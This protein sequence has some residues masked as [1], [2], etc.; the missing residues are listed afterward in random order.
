[1]K[2]CREAERPGKQSGASPVAPG[3]LYVVA[4]PIGNLED[5]TLRAL[6]VLK[7]VDLIAAEDT[8][9]SR[10]LLSHFG[11]STS[12]TSYFEHNQRVKG[13]FLI[14]K[15]EGGESV[16][17]ITDAGTPCISDPGYLLVAEAV[18]AGITVVPI[19]GACAAV[20]ALSAS[21]L[22]TDSFLFLGFLPPRGAKR[23]AKLLDVSSNQHVF[24]LYESPQRLTETIEDIYRVLGDR[25]VVVAREITKIHEEFVRGVA[26]DVLEV[27]RNREARGEVV[28]FVSPED[29]ASMVAIPD[30]DELLRHHIQVENVSVKEAVARVAAQTGLPRRIVYAKALALSGQSVQ[31]DERSDT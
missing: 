8:R 20:T 4:T 2:P 25:K 10:K 23:R 6:R 9:H 5:I 28:I 14:E 17:L 29:S 15:L 13:K 30:V 3:V 21:G 24:I 26:S 27:F 18:S 19:P 11:I 12:L 7:E 22:P 1:M 31:A 16:A